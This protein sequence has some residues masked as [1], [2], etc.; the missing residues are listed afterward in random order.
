MRTVRNLPYKS[1]SSARAIE[2]AAPDDVLQPAE[3]AAY[4]GL[5]EVQL[6]Q[7]VMS[8]VGPERLNRNPWRPTWKREALDEWKRSKH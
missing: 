2:A 6:R 4:L 8:G 1:S 5:P 3:A 7:W